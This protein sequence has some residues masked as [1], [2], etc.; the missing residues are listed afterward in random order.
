VKNA[1]TAINSQVT[2]LGRVLNTTSVANGA[3]VGSS[4]ANAA[5]D[6]MLK[7][8][9]GATF[10]L[11]INDLM[12]KGSMPLDETGLSGGPTFRAVEF[13]GN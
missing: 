7:R 9:R 13:L 8:N 4:N 10:L 6:F 2:A 3:T 1:M 11:A 5:I 12:P